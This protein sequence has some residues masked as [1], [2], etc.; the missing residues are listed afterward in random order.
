MRHV[1]ETI[2]KV[3]FNCGEMFTTDIIGSEKTVRCPHCGVNVKIFK[4]EMGY[5][6]S[7]EGF[8]A[9]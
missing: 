7:D 1:T 3:C 6:T 9:S 4:A 5:S 2:N 8:G